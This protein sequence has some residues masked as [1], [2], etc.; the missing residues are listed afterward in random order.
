ME[1]EELKKQNEAPE[2]LDDISYSTLTNGYLMQNETPRQMWE[3]ISKASASYQNNQDW[4]EYFNLFWNNWLCASTP[5][6]TNSGTDR[7]LN[8]S[9]YGQ[10][11]SDS[12]ASIFD[13]LKETAMLTKNGGGIGKYY[14]NV[15]G[16]GSEIKGN[17]KSQGIIP[18]LKIE[19]SA[20]ISLSQGSSRRG[21]EAIY[22]DINH[23]DIEEF[24]EIRKPTGDINRRCINLHT[25]VCI[26]NKFMS[27][28]IS[29]DK[30]KR[31]LW[32]KLLEMRFTTGSPYIQYTDNINDNNPECYNH[33][34]LK[35]THSQLCNEIMLHSSDT[36]TYV[37]CLSSMNL[38]RWNEW[39][40]TNAVNLAIRFLDGQ[41]SE[42]IDK[43]NKQ[44]GLEKAVRFSERHRALGLGALG[45]HSLLQ[46]KNISFESL[47]AKILNTQIFKHL[48]I[49]SK[50]ATKELALEYGEP[51]YCKG[52]GIR[53]T[54]RL[55]IAPTTSN[56]IISGDVSQS[57]EPWAS[58]VFAQ[59]TAKG[60]FIRKNRSLQKL[61]KEL[62]KDTIEVWNEINENQGSVKTLDFLTEEQKEVFKTAREINQHIIIKLA[63]DR[64]K[65]ID[66]GQSLNLFFDT[67]ADPKYINEVHLEAWKQGLKGL[68][69]VRSSTVIKGDSIDYKSASDCTYCES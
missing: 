59:K 17:G 12:L 27:D 8:I 44:I 1:L 42:F 9:C 62:N 60:T 29:G 53:N 7:G 32:S 55:A 67:T 64:Q 14:G 31:N 30:N 43:A 54:H 36:E 50:K 45:F 20:I 39:K 56:A 57:I 41:M 66:Q 2:W 40:D 16:R 28:I 24:L 61:L 63:S 48:D 6:L 21:S 22:L 37:C 69:Y 34:G 33:H 51:F 46:Q 35:V 26:D 49:E 18:W 10:N 47:Q 68:Y 65:F 58:N 25:A 11:V 23:P 3:R 4:K 15:R 5:I 19:D 13:N 38:A 52:F